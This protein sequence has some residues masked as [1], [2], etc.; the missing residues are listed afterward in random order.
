MESVDSHETAT[1]GMP[2]TADK[3]ESAVFGACSMLQDPNANMV[4]RFRSTPIHSKGSL[5]L[6]AKSLRFRGL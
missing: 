2:R 5:F 1:R 3:T 4:S 6:E